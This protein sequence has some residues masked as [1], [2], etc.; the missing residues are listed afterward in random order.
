MNT[1][2]RYLTV[3]WLALVLA[4]TLL[5]RDARAQQKTTVSG[6]VREAG[7]PLAR[8]TISEKGVPANTVGSD[9]NG[10]FHITLR[11]TSNTLIISFVNFGTE[12][13]KIKDPSKPVAVM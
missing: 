9:A 4:A 7:G 1:C 2:L 8:A 11:G 10:E 13:L 5:P 3:G 12:E 6:S